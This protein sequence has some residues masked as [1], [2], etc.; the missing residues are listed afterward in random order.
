M[1]YTTIS[2][3]EE[4][5]QELNRLKQLYRTRSFDDLIQVL[6]TLEKKRRMDAFSD[7]F[8]RRL[9]ARNLSLEDIIE[10]GEAIRE[11]ILKR[12]KHLASNL[13]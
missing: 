8:R 1:A 6:I 7:E 12:R 9:E 10:S 3:K 2:L 13:E 5:K 4:T 11:D